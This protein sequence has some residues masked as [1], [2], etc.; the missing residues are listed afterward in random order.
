MKKII[1]S[2]FATLL[3]TAATHAEPVANP[4]AK[5]FL[6]SLTDK[7]ITPE[8]RAILIEQWRFSQDASGSPARAVRLTS[9]VSAKGTA[10]QLDTPAAL[11]V[12]TPDDPLLADIQVTEAEIRDMHRDIETART[13]PEQRAIQIEQFTQLN[14]EAFSQLTQLKRQAARNHLDKEALSGPAAVGVSSPELSQRQEE[15]RFL[16]SSLDGLDPE[17]RAIFIETQIN[18]SAGKS[19]APANNIQVTNP[20]HP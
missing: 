18:P 9:P 11:K 15:L 3:A 8:Q 5:L 1:F 7:A 12:P 20:E 19:L 4:E 16:Y 6:Q 14:R 10:A 2:G 17:A 13:T